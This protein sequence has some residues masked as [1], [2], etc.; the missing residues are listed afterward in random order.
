MRLLT[1]CVCTVIFTLLPEASRQSPLRS[2]D[3]DSKPKFTLSTGEIKGITRERLERERERVADLRRDQMNLQNAEEETRLKQQAKREEEIVANGGNPADANAPSTV[4]VTVTA[5]S[6]NDMATSTR[7][8]SDS[9]F[10]G[11]FGRGG[12]HDDLF[13]ASRPTAFPF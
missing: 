3:Y 7:G 5:T 12:T 2:S 4:Y 1:L 9:E 10:G 13:G 8:F 11:E 6:G